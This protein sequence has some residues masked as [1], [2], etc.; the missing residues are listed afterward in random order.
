MLSLLVL[1]AALVPQPASARELDYRAPAGCPSQADVSTSL[2][3]RAPTGRDARIDIISEAA[4]YRGDLVVGAGDH[5]L[6]RSVQARTCAAV[7][8]ALTLVVVL[9]HGSGTPTWGSASRAR[10]SR[11][12]PSSGG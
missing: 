8:D 9:D 10:A 4:G 11:T 6:A 2:D 7:V 12:A 5:R 3:A 1:A